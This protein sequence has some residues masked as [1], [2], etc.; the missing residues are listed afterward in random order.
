ML[1]NYLY[2]APTISLNVICKRTKR[3]VHAR[4]EMELERMAPAAARRPEVSELVPV[5]LALQ[6]RAHLKSAGYQTSGYMYGLPYEV[7]SG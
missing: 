2:H 4:G 1:A 3:L 6:E 7:P 5:I